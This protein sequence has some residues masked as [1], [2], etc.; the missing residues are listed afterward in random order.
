MERMRGRSAIKILGKK[1]YD[2][3]STNHRMVRK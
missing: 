1:N 3:M 2:G